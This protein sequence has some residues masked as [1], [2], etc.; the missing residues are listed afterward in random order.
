MVSSSFPAFLCPGTA[1]RKRNV[2]LVCVEGLKSAASIRKSE[3]SERPKADVWKKCRKKWSYYVQHCIVHM[4]N[5]MPLKS[6]ENPEI[7]FERSKRK[8]RNPRAAKNSRY[9]C[10]KKTIWLCMTVWN[11]MSHQCR[12]KSTDPGRHAQSFLGSIQI[13]SANPKSEIQNP[14]QKV[15]C[16]FAGLGLDFRFWRAQENHL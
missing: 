9:L 7:K 6:L 2:I 12:L 13:R 1:G 14:Y 10:L 5:K 8:H 3:I 11:P 4:L 15:G 16:L